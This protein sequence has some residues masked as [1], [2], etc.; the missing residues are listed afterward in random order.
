VTVLAVV[1]SLLLP[2]HELVG[3]T[4]GPTPAAKNDPDA[5]LEAETSAARA[6]AGAAL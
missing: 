6:E 3:P 4:G 5:E 1:L 2:D